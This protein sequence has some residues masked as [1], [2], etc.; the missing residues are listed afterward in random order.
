MR[1]ARLYAGSFVLLAAVACSNNPAAPGG[2]SSAGGALGIIGGA[3]TGTGSYRSVGALLY[4]FDQNGIIN[5]N[6]QLCTGSLIAPTVVLTAGHCL[7]FLPAGA[8][9]YV[10]F[11]ADL[12]APGFTTIT[13]AGFSI[14]PGF[15]HDQSDPI[16]LGVVMLPAGSTTGLTPLNLPPA[17]L[18]ETM[19]AQNGLKDQRFIN[20]GYG[21]DASSRGRPT[22]SYDGQRRVS[23]SQFK[24]LQKAWLGLAMNTAAT[25]EGG[26]C[27]GDSGGPKFLA[28]N[29]SMIV[30]TVSWGDSPCRAL[31]K[32]YRLDTASARSFLGRFVRLP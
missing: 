22:F 26:D 8:T 24:S 29:T 32:N 9:L 20:V 21:V 15:G 17:G 23:T 19:S 28:G 25:G 4:D 30:A 18:L 16:D 13:A 31:S 11:D 7:S 14:D 6:D 5:S 27:Y 1:I 12:S 2:A 3:P 10:T